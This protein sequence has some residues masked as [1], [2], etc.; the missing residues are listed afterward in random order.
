M[1]LTNLNLT[2]I[3]A[4]LK[5]AEND[6]NWKLRKKENSTLNAMKN[7]N[8]KYFILKPNFLEKYLI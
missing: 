4:D 6:G 2:K 3:L 7:P 1:I 5:K 8:I